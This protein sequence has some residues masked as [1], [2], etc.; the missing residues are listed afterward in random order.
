MAF[1]SFT[2]KNIKKIIGVGHVDAN[3]WT[4]LVPFKQFM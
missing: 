3:K 4:L 1:I 2:H